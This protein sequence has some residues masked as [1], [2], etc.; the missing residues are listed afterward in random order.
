MNTQGK[1]NKKLFKKTELATQKVE[2]GLL[3][4]F[5]TEFKK[6]IDKDLKIG[7]TLISA[8]GKAENKYKSLINEYIS[9]AKIG[10]KA[11]VAAKDLGV[12]LPNTFKNKIASANAGIKEAQ[13]LI[14]KIG[15]LY[16]Q[17]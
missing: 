5:E 14:N 10:G 1:V 13:N 11:E 8:L 6:I 15:Q 12:D 17:F 4:D 7:Q 2:L 3:D 9:V 16:S